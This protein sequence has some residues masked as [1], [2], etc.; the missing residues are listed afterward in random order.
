[1]NFLFYLG[2]SIMIGTMISTIYFTFIDLVVD[3]SIIIALIATGFLIF[4]TGV[5]TNQLTY[6]DLQEKVK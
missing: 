5:Y 6:M 4:G 1:M 2:L 3:L